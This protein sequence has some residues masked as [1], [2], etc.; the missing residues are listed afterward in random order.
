MSCILRVS[1]ASLDVVRL[2]AAFP[3]KP[4]RLDRKGARRAPRPRSTHEIGCAYY[5]VSRN[6]L[7][8]LP[9]QV[10]DAVQFLA[11]HRET[12]VA[13]RHFPG[14]EACVLDFGIEWKDSCTHTDRLPSDLLS[15]VGSI[16]FGIDLTHYPARDEEP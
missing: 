15:L 16:G 1:G 11:Q 3:L 7:A 12:L 10:A 4:Y 14:V 9:L 8:P 13:M 6:D 2:A 5:D